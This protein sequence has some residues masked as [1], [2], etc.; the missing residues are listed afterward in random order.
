MPTHRQIDRLTYVRT[1]PMEIK[2]EWAHPCA[3]HPLV[4]VPEK[5][6]AHPSFLLRVSSP[7]KNCLFRF[8]ES[9]WIIYCAFRN[10]SLIH[11]LNHVSGMRC[12]IMDWVAGQFLLHTELFR[13]V[14]NLVSSLTHFNLRQSH[15]LLNDTKLLET[16]GTVKACW[17]NSKRQ[18]ISSTWR[19][20]VFRKESIDFLGKHANVVRFIQV[21]TPLKH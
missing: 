3:H 19:F 11:C 18:W 10:L 8:T 12:C 21:L 4:I 5:S 7:L 9:F 1:R 2:L 15:T 16:L 17:M 20:T 6:S 14:T 13:P